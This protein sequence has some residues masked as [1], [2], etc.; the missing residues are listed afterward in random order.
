M[1]TL[2]PVTP[3]PFQRPAEMEAEA[4]GFTLRSLVSVLKVVVWVVQWPMA[5]LPTFSSRSLP[6]TYPTFVVGII[7]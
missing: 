6:L 2:R 4:T 1:L 7:R 3:L 5:L